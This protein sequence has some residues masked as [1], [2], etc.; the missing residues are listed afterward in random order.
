[1]N[2]FLLILVKPLAPLLYGLD[3]NLVGNRLYTLRCIAGYANPPAIISW[4]KDGIRW[5]ATKTD[6]SSFIGFFVYV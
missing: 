2:Y 4:H 5:S 1:M 6:V 3:E